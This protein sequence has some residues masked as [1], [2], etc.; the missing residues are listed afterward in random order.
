MPTG[1]PRHPVGIETVF[2]LESLHETG[3]RP[4]PPINQETAWH[5]LITAPRENGGPRTRSGRITRRRRW[6]R[7]VSMLRKI[8]IR[9]P[10]VSSAVREERAHS[11][12]LLLSFL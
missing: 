10:A 6:R 11:R 2:Y 3:W 1:P 5:K 8:K 9:K 4:E 12:F 7:C